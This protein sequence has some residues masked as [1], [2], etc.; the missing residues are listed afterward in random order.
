MKI[1]AMDHPV[2]RTVDCTRR[3]T[4]IEQLP[5]PPRAEQPDLLAGWFAGDPLHRP[6][7]TERDQNACAVGAELNAGA[8]LPQLRRLLEDLNA[9]SALKH[10]QRRN[11]PADPGAGDQDFW[12]RRLHGLKLTRP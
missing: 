10:R 5:G 1:A 9:D 6:F 12:W 3:N 8:E 7:Q 2:R 11:Q 4:E